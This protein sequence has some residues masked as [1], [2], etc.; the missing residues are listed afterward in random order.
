MG[1][2]GNRGGRWASRRV[3]KDSTE[4][5]GSLFQNGTAQMVKAYNI[6]VDGICRHGRIALCGLDG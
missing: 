2:S 5:A 3:L 4:D 1:T 6:S